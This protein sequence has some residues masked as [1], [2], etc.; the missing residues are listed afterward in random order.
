MVS[1]EDLAQLARDWPEY[2]RKSKKNGKKIIGYTGSFIPE[3]MIVAAGAVPHL[4]CRGGESEAV[5]ATLPYML[6]FISPYSMAQIGYHLLGLD[7]ILPM[8]DLIIAQ[9]DSCHMARLADLFEYFN[10]PTFRLGVPSDWEKSISR[11]YYYRGL[12]RLRTKLEEIT[13]NRIT[14]TGLLKATDSSNS[15]REVLHLISLLRKRARPPLGGFDFIR[16][17]HFSFM[18]ETAVAITNLRR[19]YEDYQ[20]KKT[21]FPGDAPRLI[22]AGHVVAMGDYIV[23]KIIEDAGGIIVNEFLDE[24]IRHHCWNLPAAGDMG[25]LINELGERYYLQRTPP[26]IFQ[27]AWEARTEYLKSLIRE[28][29]AEGVIWYQLCFEEIYDMECSIVSKA[30]DELQIPFLRIESSYEFSREAMAPLSTRVESFIE[31]IK[32]KTRNLKW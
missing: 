7:P 22:L 9:C 24:G 18:S 25:H 26:S 16:L 11:E 5:E 28:Y 1:I 30:M 20:N 10:L 2:L 3:E 31:S 8:L 4:I 32:I 21:P 12:A 17:N 19:L 6:R 27:P 14:N 15:L 13:G 23:L 29:H